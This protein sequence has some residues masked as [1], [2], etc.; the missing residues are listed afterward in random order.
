MLNS[1]EIPKSPESKIFGFIIINSEGALFAISQGTN[2]KILNEITPKIPNKNHLTIWKGASVIRRHRLRAEKINNY[3]T[4]MANLAATYFISDCNRII[5]KGLILGGS[6]LYIYKFRVLLNH[7]LNN[8]I[9][10]II[11][12]QYGMRIGFYDT[13]INTQYLLNNHKLIRE[14]ELISK[15]FIEIKL[16]YGVVCYGIRKILKA[17]EIGAVELL[18]FGEGSDDPDFMLNIR[19][20]IIEHEGNLSES[21]N[22]LD[23]LKRKYSVEIELITS[24]SHEGSQF[25]GTFGIGAFLKENVGDLGDLG[26]EDLFENSH[27]EYYI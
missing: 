8:K 11:N 16:N 22:I 25:I 4:S 10:R 6:E 7:G 3:L 15:F 17:L 27:L 23:W 14:R 20:I 19:N 5:I 24:I 13:I 2:N 21:E 12:L 9:L 26:E 1:P 18:L